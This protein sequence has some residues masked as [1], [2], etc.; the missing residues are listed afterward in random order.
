[1]LSCVGRGGNAQQAS[2][3]VTKEAML[4]A[5]ALSCTKA[6]VPT[7]ICLAGMAANCRGLSVSNFNHLRHF[8]VCRSETRF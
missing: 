6:L 5:A 2:F 7:C 3:L 1:M 8:V 4:T